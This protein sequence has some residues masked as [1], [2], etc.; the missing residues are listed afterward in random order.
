MK[1]AQ[2]I[3]E[4]LNKLYPKRIELHA[5]TSPASSCADFPPEEVVE[6][7]YNAGYDGIAITNHFYVKEKIMSKESMLEVYK[8]DFL[9]A[10]ETGEQL[11]IKVYLGAELRFRYEN[12]NDYLLFGFE[13][14]QLDDIYDYLDGDLRTFYREYMNDDLFLIQAHPFR[15]GMKRANPDFLNGVEA[16]NMHPHHNS[17]VTYA[18]LFAQTYKKVETIGTDY[19]H[20]NHENLAATRMKSLPENEKALVE[21]L[22]END[23]IY[24]ISGHLVV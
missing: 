5:H 7:F 1:D 21:A 22:K 10:K 8:N 24:E 9:V 18:S 4:E 15:E 2:R 11:G 6:T 14:D 12:A 19:H 16:F 13:L 3:G 23:F 17:C 20:E